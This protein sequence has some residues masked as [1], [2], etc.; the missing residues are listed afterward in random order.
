VAEIKFSDASLLT[1]VGL[2]GTTA[3]PYNLFLNDRW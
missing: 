2:I 3:V 1:V